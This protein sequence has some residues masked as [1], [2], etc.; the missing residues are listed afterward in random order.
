[1]PRREFER[2]IEALRQAVLGLGGDVRTSVDASMA[3]LRD[4]D[5][6]RSRQLIEAHREVSDRRWTIEN[7]A[8]VA[9]A[10][11]SPVAR[12]CRR[13]VGFIEIL[14]DLARIGDHARGIAEINLLL[15]AWPGRRR[16]GFL[17]S[18]ADRALAMLDDAL[19]A[20]ADDDPARARHVLVAD[21]DLDRLQD[22]VYSDVFRT[23]IEDPS[24]VQP[25]TYL[26]WVAHNL[27]RVGDRSTNV[28]ETVIYVVT[29]EREYADT[30]DAGAAGR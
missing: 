15:G 9:V 13:L 11:H 14:G 21:D 19:L 10:E 27:E 29:G 23:M 16:L 18:M 3:A 25:Q 26:L 2:E 24:Q 17:P 22:R 4:A 20:L 30:R 8:I 7:Q 5:L 28:C 6:A 12:D 1:M